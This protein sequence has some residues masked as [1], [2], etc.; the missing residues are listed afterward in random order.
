MTARKTTKKAASPRKAASRKAGAAKKPAA[1]KPADKAAADEKPPR[2]PKSPGSPKSAGKSAK[3]G[4]SST[5]V[6]M[7]HIFALRPRVK[8]S[9][10]PD[11][12]LKARRLLDDESYASIEEAA[13][14]VA[15][16][17]LELSNEPK[18]K[19]GPRRGR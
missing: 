18:G 7:G 3:S 19:H 2:S 6:N 13:R 14:A 5:A 11:D 1:R 8:A 9:F 12:L 4:I 15:N 17:A 16:R 10:R